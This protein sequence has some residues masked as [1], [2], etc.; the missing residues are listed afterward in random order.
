MQKVIS[1]MVPVTLSCSTARVK[2]MNDSN[3]HYIL[4]SKVRLQQASY[5]RSSKQ[6]AVTALR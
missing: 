4:A 3:D 6:A 1:A 5:R 2:L